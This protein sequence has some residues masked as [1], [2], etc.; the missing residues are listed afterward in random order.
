MLPLISKDNKNKSKLQQY[1]QS[2]SLISQNIN[3]KGLKSLLDPDINK[4]KI[5]SNSHVQCLIPI[6]P[7]YKNYQNRFI[8]YY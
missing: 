3:F 8:K 4:E 6:K 1:C 2:N 7:I 5:K